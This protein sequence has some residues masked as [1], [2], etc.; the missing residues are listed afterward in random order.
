[1]GLSCVAECFEEGGDVGFERR[2]GSSGAPV[3]WVVEAL[4]NVDKE[5]GGMGEWGG[6]ECG[7]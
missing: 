5:E 2:V 6:H 4:L 3:S 7:I 1:M